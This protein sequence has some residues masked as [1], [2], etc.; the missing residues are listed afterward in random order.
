M[1]TALKQQRWHHRHAEFQP[2]LMTPNILRPPPTFTKPYYIPKECKKKT[3]PHCGEVRSAIHAAVEPQAD[4]PVNQ[5]FY[6]RDRLK[7]I[8]TRD[9]II[10]VLTCSCDQCEGQRRYLS[11]QQQRGLRLIDQSSDYIDS[12]LNA[13]PPAISLFALLIFIR[14]PPFVVGFID[15]RVHDQ[16]IS[17][18]Q[19]IFLQDKIGENYWSDFH[20]RNIRDSKSLER[21]FRDNFFQFAVPTFTSRQYHIFHERTILPFVEQIQLGR[22]DEDGRVVN[23]GAYGTVYACKIWPAY[24]NLPVSTPYSTGKL[25]KIE[26]I[27]INDCVL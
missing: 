26:W 24:N 10:T 21:D 14:A 16:W 18:L 8:L 11:Q 9:R 4:V 6:P 13:R 2:C 19:A 17:D 3:M 23:E 15:R 7:R 20:R 22:R 12:I 25:Y 1:Q 27:C 5:R